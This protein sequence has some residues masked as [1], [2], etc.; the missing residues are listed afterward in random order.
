LLLNRTV[1]EFG[2]LRQ[3]FGE[4]VG[5]GDSGSHNFSIEKCPEIK[6]IGK[7]K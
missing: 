6:T 2:F 1:K 5:F 7:L 4:F 3:I